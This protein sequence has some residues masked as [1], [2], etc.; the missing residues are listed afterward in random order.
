MTDWDP[1]T[2]KRLR[3]ALAIL[4]PLVADARVVVEDSGLDAAQIQFDNKA[5]NLWFNILRYAQARR[6]VDD[7]VARALEDYPEN[8]ALRGAKVRAP[9]PVLEGPEPRNWQ[10]PAAARALEKIIGAKST[11]VQIAYLEVGLARSRS[12]VRVCLADGS[13]GTGFVTADSTLITNNHV[14]PS[15]ESAKEAIVQ[16]NYQDTAAGLSAPLEEAKLDPGTLFRTSPEDDWTAVRIAGDVA[17]WGAIDLAKVS[18]KVG[19]PVNI[20]Q[21]PGGGPKQIS[22]QANTVA[23]VGAGRVQYLTDTLPGSS[24]SPVFDAKWNVVALHHSGGWLTE[25]NAPSKATYYRNEGTSID[26]IIDGLAGG[27]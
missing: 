19:D 26:R 8:E 7:V 10:G 24:G 3:I 1:E 22:L 21:H 5:I 2:L 12:V 14:L 18:V 9:P 27:T 20:I 23:F 17:K 11:L 15:A 25:P 13:S 6:K 4:Y 16:F